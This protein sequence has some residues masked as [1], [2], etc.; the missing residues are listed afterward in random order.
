MWITAAWPNLLF[1]FKRQANW[2]RMLRVA[3]ATTLVRS[4]IFPLPAFAAQETGPLIARLGTDVALSVDGRV[5]RDRP[6]GATLATVGGAALL[7]PAMPVTARGR[8]FASAGTVPTGSVFRILATGYSSTPDQTDASPFITASG[9]HVHDGTVATNFLPFGT[10]IR[11][12]NYRPEKVF[13]VED[14]HHPRLSTRADLW[15][16]TRQD[17]IEFGVRVLRAEVVK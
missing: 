8:R 7:N 14:R 9:S 16:E 17:A 2:R 13:V 15:F 1:A 6:L 11:F 5:L 10:R 4:L 12:L 3:L